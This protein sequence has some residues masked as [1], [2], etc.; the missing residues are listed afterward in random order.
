MNLL[1]GVDKEVNE[2]QLAMNGLGRVCYEVR[3]GLLLL[4]AL[5]QIPYTLLCLKHPV[6]S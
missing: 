4:L 5:T 6:E 3:T 2:L 1:E